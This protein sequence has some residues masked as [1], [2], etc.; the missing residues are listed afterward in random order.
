LSL[1]A[2]QQTEADHRILVDADE[3]A[4]LPYSTTFRDVVK[5]GYDLVLRQAAIEQ[6]GALAFG[7]SR[8]AGSAP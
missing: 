6:R 7:K 1:V 5:Q 3:S 4:G 8:L 2:R